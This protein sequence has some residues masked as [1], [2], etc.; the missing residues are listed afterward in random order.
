MEEKKRE[1]K[2]N[3]T[4]S[5]EHADQNFTKVFLLPSKNNDEEIGHEPDTTERNMRG[6]CFFFLNQSFIN[7][8]KSTLST[9]TRQ[10]IKYHIQSEVNHFTSHI[11]LF[12]DLVEFQL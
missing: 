5:V 2:K 4:E 11:F 12:E 7:D 8:L 9:G 3:R 10:N 1:K 6:G